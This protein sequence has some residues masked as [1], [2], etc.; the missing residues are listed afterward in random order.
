MSTTILHLELGRQLYGGAKQVVYLLQA[1]QAYPEFNHVLVC[2]ED[3]AIAE[4]KLP[5]CTTLPV[6]YKGEIDFTLVAKLGRI[7]Q[8]HNVDVLHAHSRRGADVWGAFAARF[9][10]VPALCTR[11]VDNPEGKLASWKYKQYKAVVSISEGVKVV[12]SAHLNG[13]QLQPVIHSAVALDEFT[14]SPDRAWLNHTYDVPADHKV[15]ANFAQLIPR[16]G[17]SDLIVAMKQ[18]IAAYPKVT[19]LL[20]GKGKEREHYQQL[21]DQHQLGSQMKLCGFSDEVARILPSIDIVAHPALAEG[22]G[23]ILLQA[24][25]CARPV[26]ACPSGGIKEVIRDQKNGLL[27]PPQSPDALANALCSLLDNPTLAN[28]MGEHAFQTVKAHFSP[29][30]MAKSY[31]SLYSTLTGNSA[32]GNK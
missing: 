14:F 18:V 13:Q 5:G 9:N 28:Q 25:A 16:K 24:G 26:V 3:S 15:I 30:S 19:C 8:Q 12:V 20:F 31:A 7:I 10:G 6:A 23:V 2:P 22:L 21:I 1:M 32:S 4:V 27:V 11:R 17:Q 29:A